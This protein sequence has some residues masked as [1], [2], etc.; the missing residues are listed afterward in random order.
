MDPFAA[1]LDGH[2]HRGRGSGSH[3]RPCLLRWLEVVS[4]IRIKSRP[5][6]HRLLS[7][8]CMGRWR[9]L[10]CGCG[11]LQTSAT[12][13]SPS[14]CR[15]RMRA[16]VSWRPCPRPT[17]SSLRHRRCFRRSPSASWFCFT[18]RLQFSWAQQPGGWSRR[19]KGTTDEQPEGGQRA[20]CPV[21]NDD[22]ADQ[23]AVRPLPPP[24]SSSSLRRPNSGEPLLVLLQPHD[25]H[26]SSTPGGAITSTETMLVRNPLEGPFAR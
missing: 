2:F 17:G 8:R 1:A 14:R 22:A 3:E 19:V 9:P 10:S 24:P 16:S 20:C 12:P 6:R 23:Q 26:S 21:H 7:Q 25:A 11:R 4:A 13:T 18:C 15:S 5:P